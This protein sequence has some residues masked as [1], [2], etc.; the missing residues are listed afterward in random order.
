MEIFGFLSG[1]AAGAIVGF[2]VVAIVG[3]W[4]YLRAVAK[5]QSLPA[6]ALAAA[7]DF[8]KEKGTGLAIETLSRRLF[9]KKS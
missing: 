6:T 8:A 3:Y 7:T 9:A 5:L 1:F 4:L 2:V